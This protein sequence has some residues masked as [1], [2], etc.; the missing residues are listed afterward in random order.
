MSYRH[1]SDGSLE[2]GTNAAFRITKVSF[3]VTTVNIRVTTESAKLAE[4]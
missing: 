3:R 2:V 4:T 1:R